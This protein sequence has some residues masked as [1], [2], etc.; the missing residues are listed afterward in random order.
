MPKSSLVVAPS[1]SVAVQGTVING[2][3]WRTCR[4]L[5]RRAVPRTFLA[6][7]F[8][9]LAALCPFRAQAATATASLN[10]SIVITASCSINAATLTFP[11]TAGTSLVSTA[12]SASTTVSV[13]CTSG[14]PYS[15]A[16]DNGANA[17]GNQRRMISGSNLLNYGLYVDAAHAFP[18]S[19]A[20]SSTSCTV[21][22]DCY[23]GTGNGAAQSVSIYGLVPTT[24][25][26][27]AAGTYTDTVTMTITY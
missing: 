4:R 21:S 12:V 18:W 27:P 9:A 26:A 6:L 15:I 17:S 22:G 23:L 11:P 19:T 16:M 2:S 14:S 10:V 5:Q 24:A 8:A 25:T 1:R 3:R 13:T 7:G 20:T